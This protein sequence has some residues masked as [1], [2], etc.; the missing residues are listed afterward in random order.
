MQKRAKQKRESTLVQSH[1]V[2]N[3]SLTLMAWMQINTDFFATMNGIMNQRNVMKMAI[4]FSLP[5][6]LETAI[7]YV[8]KKHF[9]WK[10]HI[11]AGE[12]TG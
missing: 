2:L 9:V 4:S 10:R 7:P 12:Q 3:L 8:T 5:V 1:S 6:L 11:S